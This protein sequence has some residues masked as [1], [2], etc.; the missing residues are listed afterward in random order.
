VHTSV[1]LCPALRKGAAVLRARDFSI[2]GVHGT[3]YKSGRV[4][5]VK[6]KET[7]VALDDPGIRW[8]RAVHLLRELR[9]CTFVSTEELAAAAG[10]HE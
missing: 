5:P 3:L 7:I 10:V 1:R 9:G 2:A 6:V 4:L 8:V